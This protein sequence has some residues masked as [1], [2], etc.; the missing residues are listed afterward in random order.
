MSLPGGS[1]GKDSTC[2]VGDLG[3]IPGLV[4]SAGEGTGYPLQYYWASTVAQLVKNPPAMQETWVQSLGW[5][6]PL[7]EGRATHSSILAWRI[8]WT[9]EPSGLYSLWGHKQTRLSN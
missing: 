2:N 6:D 5:E 7:E 1:N 4:R 9:E 3:S 8:P